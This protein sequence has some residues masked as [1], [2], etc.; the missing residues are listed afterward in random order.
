MREVFG[1]NNIYKESLGVEIEKLVVIGTAEAID[2]DAKGF[3]K[4]KGIQVILKNEL[5]MILDDVKV[6]YSEV[7]IE[8]KNRYSLEQIKREI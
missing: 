8:N 7:C 4:T 5:E 6:Y 1:A 2:P 3:A